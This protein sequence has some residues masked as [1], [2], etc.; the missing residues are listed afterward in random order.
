MSTFPRKYL[1]LGAALTITGFLVG[2]FGPSLFQ[3]SIQETQPRFSYGD[4]SQAFFDRANAT[5]EQTDRTNSRSGISAHHLLVADKIAQLFASL[6]TGRERTVVILSPNHFDQ[7]RASLQTTSGVWDTPYGD[8]FVDTQAVTHLLETVPAL[9]REPETFQREHGIS[10]LT[11]FLRTWFPRA[12]LVPIVIH[13]SATSEEVEQL[14]IQ[15]QRQLPRAVVIASVDMSHN[16]PEHI[17]TFHDEV[18][19]RAIAAGGCDCDLEVDANRVLETLFAVNRL[20]GTQTWNQTHHGS[21]LAMEAAEVFTDNTSHILGYFHKGKPDTHPFFSMQFVGDVMLDRGVRRDMAV[22]GVTAPWQNVKRFL[23][24]T[25]LQ[26]A[27]LE[28]TIGEQAS[29]A[30]VQPPFQFV[31]DPKAVEEMHKHIDVVSQAN[32]HAEDFGPLAEEATHEWL[33]LLGIPW[34]G[35]AHRSDVIY[36]VDRPGFAISLI[37]WHQFGDTIERLEETIRQEEAKGRFVMV[38]PH[39]GNEY[40][41]APQPHQRELA[42]RMVKAGA[43]LVIGSHPHVVQGIEVIDGVPVLYSLGNFI[44]DQGFDQTKIGLLAGVLLEDGRVKIQLSPVSTATSQ[45]T[46][47]SDAEA[48]SFFESLSSLSSPDLREQILTG[49]LTT[50]YE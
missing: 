37:G 2:L 31:F 14:A 43:D 24:G 18:T 41:Q 29:V 20:R 33:D 13:D 50:S 44:F 21:S 32:N 11:P 8:L 28:G 4:T 27:N 22:S 6:G 36:R 42:Q 48:A 10:Q 23:S 46:P 39:W 17:Q 45:P 35:S 40:I 7:G 16:L 47:F 9:K 15:L 30:T 26:V 34:F 25:H 5:A 3:P 49:Q 1:L 12:K 19:L 38:Y